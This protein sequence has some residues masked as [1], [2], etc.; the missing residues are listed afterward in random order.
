MR[1]CQPR[2]QSM[3]R[4]TW[5]GTVPDDRHCGGAHLTE[6]QT[7]VLQ[8]KC[9]CSENVCCCSGLRARL[10]SYLFS[11][12]SFSPASCTL[13]ATQRTSDCQKRGA[14]ESTSGSVIHLFTWK[15][16]KFYHQWTDAN[17][18]SLRTKHCAIPALHMA[19]HLGPDDRKKHS[20][21]CRSTSKP[22]KH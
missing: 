16:L 1:Q 10:L 22:T 17:H 15:N 21:R 8:V 6:E 5:A 20:A 14:Q 18:V 11:L 3:L 7:E 19:A 9:M 12:L 4:E 2:K 13:Q